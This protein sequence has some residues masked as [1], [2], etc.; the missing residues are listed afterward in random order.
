MAQRPTSVT[1]AIQL[2]MVLLAAGLV[3]TV[4]VVVFRDDL[5]AAWTRGHPVDS[6]IEPLSFVPVVIV[7]YVVLAVMTLTLIPFLGYGHNWARHTIAATLAV[8]AF[9]MLGVLRTGPPTLFVVVIVAAL[10]LEAAIG[11]YLYHRDTFRY[12]R[13][14]PA[15]E[16]PTADRTG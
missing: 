14:D 15:A 16:Q 7:L 4:L 2:L 8:I 13:E 11:Y 9:S 6:A 12:V 1:R 3:V 5:D 10:L